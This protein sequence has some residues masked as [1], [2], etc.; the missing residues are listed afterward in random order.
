[1]FIVIIPVGLI[2]AALAFI[3]L[4]PLFHDFIPFI[5]DVIF[6]A[7]SCYVG[8]VFI[9]RMSERINKKECS[10]KEAE[11]V[12]LSGIFNLVVLLLGTVLIEIILHI[13]GTLKRLLSINSVQLIVGSAYYIF[14]LLVD[15]Y[16]IKNRLLCPALF[17]FSVFLMFVLYVLI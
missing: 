8:L 11:K 16:K 10:T 7:C 5:E 17:I 9:L 13:D 2:L 12:A 15:R 3:G 4:A 1:M 14:H 6:L